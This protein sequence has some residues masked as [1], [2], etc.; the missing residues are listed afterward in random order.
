MP[1]PYTLYTE[2]ERLAILATAFAEQLSATHVL[3]RFGVKPVTYY[4]W[5]RKRGL[6]STQG[7]RP[8]TA[9]HGSLEQESVA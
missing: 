8:S 3:E 7:Q 4:S 1:R 5:R 6:K 9:S 2:A